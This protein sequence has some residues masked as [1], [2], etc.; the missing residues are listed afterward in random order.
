[1]KKLLSNSSCVGN[2]MCSDVWYIIKGDVMRFSSDEIN[3]P[4][5]WTLIECNITNANGC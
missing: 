3:R 4:I 2:A 5:I 1:M